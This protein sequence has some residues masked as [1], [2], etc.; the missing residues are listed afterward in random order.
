[1]AYP[2]HFD[3]K[4]IF[5]D[6]VNAIILATA[7]FGGFRSSFCADCFQTILYEAI[8]FQLF[9]HLFMGHRRLLAPVSNRRSDCRGSDQA[10]HLFSQHNQP[11]KTA[12][13]ALKA[14]FPH[15]NQ[16]YL[17]PVRCALSRRKDMTRGARTLPLWAI[18]HVNLSASA[19]I[20]VQRKRPLRS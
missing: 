20:C 6:V 19:L 10:N 11:K 18:I 5:H 9:N 13:P 12:I 17:S 8:F 7:S 4:D 1:M 2:N 16:D 14:P 3:N 15:Q